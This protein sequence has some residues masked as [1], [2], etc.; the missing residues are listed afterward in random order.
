MDVDLNARCDAIEECYEFMLAYAAQGVVEE[1]GSQP[2]AQ[3][4]TFLGRAEEA[5]IGLA[6]AY[7]V[8]VERNRLEP[9]DRYAAFLA[10]LDRDARDALAAL[11]LV[12]AQPSLS[13]QIIDNL[14]AS[15]HVRALLTDLFLIDE[16][17][18]GR[19]R[20]QSTA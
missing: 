9:A 17:L 1:A 20:A 7:R 18:K 10:V 15:I 14:N 3:L 11:Q 8:V 5:L 2:A 16:I 4:R 12:I 13:S 6:D 19:T